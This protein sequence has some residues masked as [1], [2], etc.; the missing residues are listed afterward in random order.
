LFTP[1]DEKAYVMRI[2]PRGAALVLATTV[3][4]GIL[5]ATPA[6]ADPA[7]DLMQAVIS[8]RGSARCAPL[9]QDPL[10]EHAA[11]IVNRSTFDYLN[12]TAQNVPLDD[13]H[14]TALV[15]DLGIAGTKSY[16]LQGAGQDEGNAVRGLLLQGYNVIP[17]CSYT[18]IGASRLYEPDSGFYLVVVVLVGS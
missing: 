9:Q 15:K 17:D 8:A 6:A 13:P 3:G 18:G 16:S 10:I 12:H 2:L 5:P 11:E 14:P 7:T 4:V 1:T